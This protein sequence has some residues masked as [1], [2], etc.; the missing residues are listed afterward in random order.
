MSDYQPTPQNVSLPDQPRDYPDF[1]DLKRCPPGNYG[2]L[3]DNEYV[4]VHQLHVLMFAFQRL[5]DAIRRVEAKVEPINQNV[6]LLI[7]SVRAI[8]A[9]VDALIPSVSVP[10]VFGPCGPQPEMKMTVF[11]PPGPEADILP[12]TMGKTTGREKP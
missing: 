11:I 7:Q 8:E 4:H 9:K 1:E 6:N 10:S 2:P 12:K 5:L 3:P